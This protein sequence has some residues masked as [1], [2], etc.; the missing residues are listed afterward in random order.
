MHT[1]WRVCAATAVPRTPT[2]RGRRPGSVGV[3]TKIPEPAPCRAPGERSSDVR[4]SGVA[5][6]RSSASRRIPAWQGFLNA[7]TVR[8]P[9]TA[10]ALAARRRKTETALQRVHEAIARLRREKAQASVATVARRADVSRTFLYDNPEA[11]AAVASA[12]AKTGERRTWLLAGLDDE[13]E[14]TWRERA[15]NAEDARKRIPQPRSRRATPYRPATRR[16]RRPPAVP[17]NGR[18]CQPT[19]SGPAASLADLL[20]DQG[21]CQVLTTRDPHHPQQLRAP[22][23]PGRRRV[24]HARLSTDRA[25]LTCAPQF[26]SRPPTVLPRRYEGSAGQPPG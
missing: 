2:G 22:H 23:K 13:R 3:L 5:I 8:G 6:P 24:R 19:R 4:R 15:L 18:D 12:M 9:R 7:A 20:T 16:T 21:R 14:A 25:D 1:L 11:R 26:P 17:A 10:A